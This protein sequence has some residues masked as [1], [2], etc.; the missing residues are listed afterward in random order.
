MDTVDKIFFVFSV[1]DF[2]SKGFLSN[3]EAN[4]LFRSITKGL[5]KISNSEG[6]NSA[7][8]D[9]GEKFADLLFQAMDKP[10]DTGRVTAEEFKN[11]SVTHPVV[12]N[13]LKSASALDIPGLASDK[14]MVESKERDVWVSTINSKFMA[15]KPQALVHA[16][17]G[18]EVEFV[19]TEVDR[20]DEVEGG[21]IPND[22]S[23]VKTM[24]TQEESS[25]VSKVIRLKPDEV[26]PPRTDLP[27]DVFESLWIGGINVR[28]LNGDS[29]NDPFAAA[30]MH[31]C[32]RYRSLN[33][34]AILYTSGT[35]VVIIKKNEETSMWSQEL[36]NE[37]NHPISALDINYAKN[38]LVTADRSQFSTSVKTSSTVL[39]RIVVW[40]LSTMKVKHRFEVPSNVKYLDINSLGTLIVTLFEDVGGTLSIRDIS[41]G[42]VVYSKKI[43]MDTLADTVNDVRFF[44]TTTMVAV[45]CEKQ[46]V[47][48][49]IDEETG[50][51]GKSNMH[52]YEERNALYGAVGKSM[53]G[54]SA[55]V[56]SRLELPDEFITGTTNGHLI[57]WRGRTVAQVI[58]AHRGR[59]TALDYNPSTK[60][61][62]SGGDDGSIKIFEINDPTSKVPKNLVPKGPR[63]PAVRSLQN[64][65]T[66]DILRHNLSGYH[67][68]SV[69][70]ADG[71]S[72]AVVV[73]ST[74]ELVEVTC[75][76]A[77]PTPEEL[78]AAA[79][80]AGGEDGGVPA[81]KGQL[82]DDLHNGPLVSGHYVVDGVVGS[83]VTSACKV[84]NSFATGGTDGTVR[85]WQ[86]VGEGDT[87]GGFKVIKTIKMDCSVSAI[88]ASAANL[89][90]ALHGTNASRN[91]SIHLFGLPEGNFVTE[92][93]D[94]SE[95]VRELKFSGEG[96][97]LT[98]LRADGAIYI[99][100]QAEG[101]WS[102]KGKVEGGESADRYDL[103]SDNQYIRAY[104][105]TKDIKVFDIGANFGTEI[106][107]TLPPPMEPKPLEEG[108]EPPPVPGAAI[109]ETLRNIQWASNNCP[110][111]W[112]TIAAN[113]LHYPPNEKLTSIIERSNHLLLATLDSGAFDVTRAPSMTKNMVQ[114]RVVT[115]HTG[116]ISSLFFFD[117]GGAKLFTAGSTDGNIR[118][119]KVNYDTDEVEV[120]L[121]DPTAEEGDK[122]AEEDEE[123]AKKALPELYDSGD[124]EDHED[125]L[126]LKKHLRRYKQVDTVVNENTPSET[127][128]EK[129]LSSWTNLLGFDNSNAFVKACANSMQIQHTLLP[130]DELEID[131]IYG[132]S[133]RSTRSSV[134][135]NNQGL[136]VYPAGGIS[137]IYD[138]VNKQQI[139]VQQPHKDEITCLDIHV[140]KNIGVSAHKGGGKIVAFLW[141]ASTGSIIRTFDCGHVNAISAIK[142]SPCGS[143]IALANQDSDHSVSIFST[144][145]G[146]LL[147]KARGGNQKILCLAFSDAPITTAGGSSLRLL[148]GGMKHFKLLSFQTNL[149]TMQSKTGQYG[150]DVRKSHVNCVASLP[151][152]LGEGDSVSGNEFLMGM[153]DGTVGVLARGEN[154]V[155]SFNPVMKG[156]VT[157]ITVA[158]IK[159]A[160]IEE[161][162]VFKVIVGGVNGFIKVL[163]QELQPLSE[164]NLYIKD[165]GLYPLG[166]VRGFKSLCC[167]KLNRK[168]LFS[169]AAGEVGEIDLA[170]GEDLNQN[171]PLVHSHFRDQLNALACHPLRQECL[172]AGEDKSLRV[173]NMET[174]SLAAIIE[175]PGP[176]IAGAFAPN[177]HLIVV[178]LS[179][180]LND[181]FGGRIS[182]VSY[183][184]GKVRI[185]HTTNDAREEIAT[186]VFSPDGSKVYAGSLDAGIYV[187]DALNNFR[188]ITTLSGHT[189]GVRSLDMSA[190][191]KYMISESVNHQV[192]VWELRTN[193]PLSNPSEIFEI[194][195][196]TNKRY[197]VRQNLFG[198]NSLGI[199]SGS[200][201]ASSSSGAV[202]A[203]ILTLAQSHDGKLLATGD[204][205]GHLKVFSNPSVH[206]QSPY[207]N[208][209]LHTPGGLSKVSFSVDDRFLMSIGKFDKT[210]VQWKIVK[211][212]TV[213]D[214]P[215]SGPVAR[216]G[217]DS[218][219]DIF[220]Q[221][222]VVK[223][224][225]FRN[226]AAP[227]TSHGHVV[228]QLS[229]IIGAGHYGEMSDVPAL[230]HATFCGHGEILTAAG[231]TLYA[232]EGESA[233]RKIRIWNTQAITTQ[234]ATD[235]TTRLDVTAIGVSP[236]GRFVMVGFAGDATGVSPIHLYRAPT[237][238]FMVELV[239]DAIGG[240][241]SASFSKNSSL[242]AALG[243]DTQ[244][245]LYVFKTFSGHWDDSF[246][247]HRSH[248]SAAP[249]HQLAFLIAPDSP[250]RTST[251]NDFVTAG[252][253]L[254]KFWRIQGLN[255]VCEVGQYGEEHGA[256]SAITSVVGGT[257]NGA[258]DEAIS[259]DV[260][261]RVFLWR[262]KFR[263]HLLETHPSSITAMTSYSNVDGSKAGFIA[264]SKDMVSVWTTAANTTLIS[265]ISIYDLVSRL[266]WSSSLY[267]ASQSI[268]VTA[269]RNLSSDPEARQIVLSLNNGLILNY[270]TDSGNVRKLMEAH[271]TNHTV[272]QMIAHPKDD[273]LVLTVSD[274]HSL[275][276]WDVSGDTV[277]SGVSVKEGLPKRP[278]YPGASLV[279]YLH[280][281]HPATA[282]TFL[283]D[284][285][286]LVAISGTD[287]DGVSGAILVIDIKKSNDPTN[288]PYLF[289]IV[290]RFHNVGHGAIRQLRLSPGNRMLAWSSDAGSIY[291]HKVNGESLDPV[292]HFLA[293]P[294]S[295]PVI[296]ADFSSDCR[297]VRSFGENHVALNGKVEVN[298]FDFELD[299]GVAPASMNPLRKYAGGKVQDIG[300]LESLRVIAW[301]S[302]GSPAAPEVRGLSYTSEGDVNK[303][304]ATNSLS[305][306]HDGK[307]VVAGYQDGTVRLYRLVTD[308]ICLSLCVDMIFSD[309]RCHQYQRLVLLMLLSSYRI[310]L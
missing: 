280:V 86:V 213:P 41:S 177:G 83:I 91:G 272:K 152:A 137:I 288:S 126:N 34:D 222:F 125:G 55:T 162:P 237:G 130:N 186:V 141:N 118:V 255:L 183:L 240:I 78:E 19:Y 242:A 123:G 173:W 144:E 169:T 116:P 84:G 112:D 274:D 29:S 69:A 229:H 243:R 6:F 289:T 176:A 187:Y 107:S 122:P 234:S 193:A 244:H 294:D 4:L 190:D 286:I 212:S 305:I 95:A 51:M 105:P 82:G 36:F 104:Y 59:V 199:F 297:Y 145:E 220:D 158:R 163:D 154:K 254:I 295:K 251:N 249:I 131:W 53:V 52:M 278:N 172:T 192:I 287:Q 226:D 245:T 165:Y 273:S 197:H 142:F 37:H 25:W 260:D 114:Q 10:K 282:I 81:P 250:L 100:A 279:G 79:A 135:Y 283:N 108:E 68:S 230:P 239:D 127:F 207:R 252:H 175:L 9:D 195:S 67:I 72:K 26:P 120:D 22:D 308:K 80:E 206:I 209:N 268:S 256:V 247:L 150:A 208:Y 215:V 246:V 157:A 224:V 168:I 160:T 89:A 110:Y 216:R 93:T 96:N 275:R 40:D 65:A 161:P 290:N 198:L 210:L 148:Q 136:I 94:S 38:I 310:M 293:H 20:P 182:V 73:T 143:Y 48:F 74:N 276:L 223:G 63:P 202:A 14:G 271:G 12:G 71:A 217:K 147:A 214:V 257:G 281:P 179:R 50:V 134:K 181:P 113:S 90:V 75:K 115:A 291:I 201:P 85:L 97:L 2:D 88:G 138:K 238:D 170:T 5:A 46:G 7:S 62:I 231:K 121:P 18:D 301:G 264:A 43:L 102:F 139:H 166:R 32:A 8:P 24:V 262:G 307:L 204:Q 164:F 56:C 298:F 16:L 146:L 232:I 101:A 258:R 302:V 15:P 33:N 58:E 54:T 42:K 309:I 117:E 196:E 284:T 129:A 44:G 228:A 45:C 263:H 300:I 103:S 285:K 60:T 178:S 267:T 111:N 180:K 11:Y 99:Y 155:A 92:V 77:L 248:V 219:D 205:N 189:E 167:D 17:K 265:Q 304:V 98:A 292:G 269:V 266:G 188:L 30:Q 303:I 253:G 124:E 70:L 119:W 133:S 299:G 194:L 233:G 184:Q 27:E 185:V 35:H 13:W 221:S 211:S 66:F 270:S 235:Q 109:I 277:Y 225:D 227:T 87:F 203:D 159:A 61:L 200:L 306:S 49:F 28:R 3:D 171:Q 296:A 140:G 174:H 57:V 236:C 21:A 39:N 76:L 259:G 64:S 218:P 156:G 241:A 47:R 132:C 23:T 149:R 191:G 1:Y 128:A 151:M 153:S 261:G 31:R 106:F